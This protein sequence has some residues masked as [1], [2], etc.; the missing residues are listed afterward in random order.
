MKYSLALL[1][2]FAL[3]SS[4]NAAQILADVSPTVGVPGSQ[5]VVLSVLAEA[6]ESFRGFD[7]SFNGPLGQVN[8]LGFDTVF[9]DINAFFPPAD[10]SADSQFTFV[11]GDVLV[12]G[13]AEGPNLLQAAVSGLAALS[14]PNPQPFV[15][16]VLDES[17][18]PLGADVQFT[19]ALDMGLDNPVLRE[20]TVDQ[21]IP[22]PASVALAG[23][24]MVG[25]L[26]S[27]R[28][29]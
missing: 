18:D 22:E 14:L 6:G 27:R 3:V 5:T 9:Q 13:P 21:L 26:V 10:V 16:L 11:S 17:V 8:P 23:L 29:S 20:G 28:R 19:L 7:A 4:A 12:I 25:C 24:A 2:S 1:V 15:Q